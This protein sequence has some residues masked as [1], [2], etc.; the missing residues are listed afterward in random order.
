LRRDQISISIMPI[1]AIQALN[2][3]ISS[4]NARSPT[5]PIRSHPS[6]EYDLRLQW[7]QLVAVYQCK[8]LYKLLVWFVI[9][10]GDVSI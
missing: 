7:S 2:S 8:Y 10:I 9:S 4:V 5:S 1:L 3:G 6:L